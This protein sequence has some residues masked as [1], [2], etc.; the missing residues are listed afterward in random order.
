MNIQLTNIGKRYNYEWIFK[1]IHFEFTSEN[2]YAIL[3]SNGSG[4]STLLQI[5][6]GNFLPS[7]GEINYR[8][9]SNEV[10]HV[11]SS[12]VE[13]KPIDPEEVYKQLSIATPYLDLFDEFTLTESI[14]F[15]SKFKPF[16][17][18]LDT[19][20]IIALTQLEKAKDKQL[21]YFSSGMKQRVRLALAILS[22]TQLLLLDEPTS[23]LD[24]NAIA[25]YQQLVQTYSK[26]RLIIV[27]SN[28]LEYEYAPFCNLL[29][30]VEDYKK[31]N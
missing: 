11:S 6:A 20:E 27:A 21:K 18:G 4:K 28:Q 31:R 30:N 22:D 14:E 15:H 9:S 13:N 12:G 2:S 16:M 5:L 29:L 17:Q 8:I 24:K 3:G 1:G 19:K 23:N 10:D 26:N 25:W 7:E